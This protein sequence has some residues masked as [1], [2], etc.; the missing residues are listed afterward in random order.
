MDVPIRLGQVGV[1][2]TSFRWLFPAVDAQAEK[3]SADANTRDSADATVDSGHKGDASSGKGHVSS[4]GRASS[5][6][7]SP[8]VS[9]Q[10]VVDPR[11]TGME[12]AE[13]AGFLRAGCARVSQFP[14]K[15][16][17]L[18]FILVVVKDKLIDLWGS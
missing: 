18:F 5:P 7:A 3:K 11:A 6:E 9:F 2:S 13:L 10:F 17:N 1:G 4:K 15:S 14:H 16:V 12:G 8:G